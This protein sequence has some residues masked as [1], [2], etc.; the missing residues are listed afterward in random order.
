MGIDAE[1]LLRIK[2]EKPTEQRI[3]EWAWNICSAL[4]SEH[5][6]IKDGLPGAAYHEAIKLW[7]RRFDTHP[8]YAEF[9]A[10]EGDWAARNIA[11][12][13]IIADIG[14]PP[15]QRRRAIEFTNAL[16]PIEDDE[17]IPEPFREPGRMSKQDGDDIYAKPDEWLLDVNLWSRYYGIGYER[18]DILT[19]CAVAE[20]CEAN[21]PNCEVWYGGDS[22]GVV[23][24]P[25]PEAERAKLRKHL[26][27]P[28]GRSY[29]YCAAK[30]ALKGPG[31]CGL[32][33][34][35]ARFTESG[36]GRSYAAVYCG[37]CGKTFETRDGAPWAEKKEREAA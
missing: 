25:F 9:K 28:E 4:G 7:H 6:F 34:G 31:P 29:R 35:S 14:E 24:K 17:G 8:R 19:I 3:T 20:W 37:G 26:Y 18:G 2:G 1:I 13:A 15:E 36:W 27:S 33:P 5:F 16:Y 30:T 21:I 12:D 22:S 10:R 23:A 11:R 32:C